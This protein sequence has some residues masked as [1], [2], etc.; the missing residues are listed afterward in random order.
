MNAMRGTRLMLGLVLRRERIH[1]TA[2]YGLAGLVLVGVAAGIAATYP[3]EAARQQ[4]AASV[5]SSGQELFLIGPIFSAS[6]GGIGLWRMTG[7]AAL[8]VSLASIFTVMR[9]TRATE[10]SGT[11]ELLSAARIGRGAPLAAAMVVAAVGSAFCGVIVGIG[12]IAIGGS[13]FGSLLAGAQVISF[14]LLAATI[15]ALT[16]QML[17]TA[18]AGTG[19]AV[20]VVGGFYLLRGAAD[21]HGG[22]ISWVSPFEWIAAIRPFAEDNALPL[23]PVLVLVTALSGAGLFIAGRRDFGAGLMHD[24][25]GPAH[26]SNA[27]RGP[28]TLALK[29]S[30]PT[31][32]SWSLG[33][34]LVA[35]LIG[36]VSAVVDKQAPLKLSGIEGGQG[37]ITVVLY[38]VPI[39]A[40]VCGMQTT[41][42]LRGE[43]T[44]GRAE[45][46]LS[47]P[48]D[49]GRWGFAYAISGA[50]AGFIVLF[51]FGVGLGLAR[52]SEMLTLIVASVAKAP[53]VWFFVAVTAL[54]LCALP[55]A[56]GGIAYALLAAFVSLELLVEFRIVPPQVLYASPFA[57]APQL[58]D[59]PLNAQWAIL[60]LAG[61]AALIMAASRVLRQMDIR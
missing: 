52:P 15:A 44:S 54:L 8:V 13:P 51:T 6:L 59:G 50:L 57:L 40:A 39:I 34:L 43:V 24:R 47:R 48:V 2:W 7:V 61:I 46:V 12:F 53:A 4:L 20:A 29:I 41:L 5:N 27:L 19:I 33:A 35:F 17:R 32:V 37:L 45:A 23:L 22:G 56:A 55:R 10:E 11:T 30:R 16:G 49:R 25:L 26:A 60:V 38:L 42:R 21:A 18:R 3:T 28:V 1:A 36:A 31:I 14:G 58:P 9:N